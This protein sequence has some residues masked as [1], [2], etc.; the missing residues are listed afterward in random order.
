MACVTANLLV[1]HKMNTVVHS[2]LLHGLPNVLWFAPTGPDVVCLFTGINYGERPP[3]SRLC[4]IKMVYS[5]TERTSADDCLKKSLG[6]YI[7][8]T[9]HIMSWCMVSIAIPNGVTVKTQIL[10]CSSR[11]SVP[12][13]T[14]KTQPA[15]MRSISCNIQHLVHQQSQHKIRLSMLWNR[16]FPHYGLAN[17][18]NRQ[19]TPHDDVLKRIQATAAWKQ[20]VSEPWEG[21]AACDQERSLRRGNEE[22][23]TA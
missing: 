1:L 3:R 15:S 19:T 12:T 23:L 16:T 11:F 6:C 20:N 13:L 10:L 4:V 2:Y 14:Y 7:Q 8:Q 17:T 18:A 5:S 21:C 22:K 9:L